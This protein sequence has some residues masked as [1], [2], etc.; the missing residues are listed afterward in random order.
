MGPKAGGKL[1]VEGT[2]PRKQVGDPFLQPPATV[3][4]TT[5]HLQRQFRHRDV[6]VRHGPTQAGFVGI[7]SRGMTASSGR[8]PDHVLEAG[9]E[10]VGLSAADF[11]PGQSRGRCAYRAPALGLFARTDMTGRETLA[12]HEAGFAR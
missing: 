5:Q 9:L 1:V 8:G 12:A 6:P 7:G 3:G 4:R 11:E 10:R 2:V